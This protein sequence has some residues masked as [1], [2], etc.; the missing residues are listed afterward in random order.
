[1]TFSDI[2]ER[3]GQIEARLTAIETTRA[4]AG[5]AKPRPEELRRK[6]L[7]SLQARWPMSMREISH[8]SKVKREKVRDV[9][10]DL[11]A[12]GLVIEV[13]GLVGHSAWF[14]PVVE[15]VS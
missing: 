2:V 6:V 12:E 5:P 7:D 8:V 13:E 10:F 9:L 11:A 1:M 4:K 14:A 15:E 3:L